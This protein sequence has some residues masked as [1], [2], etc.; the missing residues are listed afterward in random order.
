MTLYITRDRDGQLS[1][2]NHMPFRDTQGYWTTSDGETDSLA[3]CRSDIL[4]QLLAPAISH[5]VPYD[6]PVVVSAQVEEL[7]EEVI[8]DELKNIHQ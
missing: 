1:V 6:R 2:H 7:G 8:F 4:R 3:A 5:G